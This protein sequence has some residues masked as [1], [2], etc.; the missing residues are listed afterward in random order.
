[1]LTCDHSQSTPQESLVNGIITDLSDILVAAGCTAPQSDII[2]KVTSEFKQRITSL[3]KLA[4]RLGKMFN[5]VI[6]SNFEVFTAQPGDKLDGETMEDTN[7]CHAGANKETVLCA[8]HLGLTKWIPVGPSL[9]EKG[10]KRTVMVLKAKVLLVF[11][12][13]M[14]NQ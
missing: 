9:W 13:D 14:E 8:T 4:A 2:S 10:E 12:L 3:V 7:G 6:S 11:F 5:E 1:M